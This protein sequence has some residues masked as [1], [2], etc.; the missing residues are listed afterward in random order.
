M[1]LPQTAKL[2]EDLPEGLRPAFA[3]IRR[4]A[5]G[6][7]FGAT[8]GLAFFLFAIIHPLFGLDNDLL[9]WL[10]GNNFFLGYAP[11]PLGACIGLLWG[12][13]V[14]FASGWFVAW[15][16]NVSIA[17]WVTATL[18]KAQLRQDSEFLDEI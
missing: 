16:R 2:T 11:T 6:V 10:V 8:L 13:G 4:R 14:G 18:A 3:P 1:S 5:L 9:V 12:L 17:L 7:G 15:M